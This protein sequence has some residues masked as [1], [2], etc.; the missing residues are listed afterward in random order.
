M[1]LN[2]EPKLETE[3]VK[4]IF[5]G[6]ESHYSTTKLDPNKVHEIEPAT[7]ENEMDICKNFDEGVMQTLEAVVKAGDNYFGIVKVIMEDR[8][9]DE[10]IYNR[11]VI[12][13]TALTRHIPGKRAALVGFIDSKNGPVTIGRSETNSEIGLLEIDDLG[14]TTS[15]KHFAL[16][17]SVDGSVGIIDLDSKNGT[18]V[19]EQKDDKF[20]FGLT[21]E[22]NRSSSALNPIDDIGLNFWSAK[23]ANIRDRLE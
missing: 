10:A 2:V 18:T 14:V 9:S 15:R 22:K 3:S 6:L 20:K 12:E 4:E 16:A 17:E 13:K 5:D 7:I 19:F 21:P 23:S 8:S 11:E 1:S